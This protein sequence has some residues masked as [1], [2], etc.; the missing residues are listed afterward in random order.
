MADRPIVV[1]I[2]HHFDDTDKA[3]TLKKTLETTL[4]YPAVDLQ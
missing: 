1:L 3:E 2:A 4:G